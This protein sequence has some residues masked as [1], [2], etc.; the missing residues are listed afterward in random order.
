MCVAEIYL[1]VLAKSTAADPV[2]SAEFHQ[3]AGAFCYYRRVNCNRNQSVTQESE[4]LIAD[5]WE[6]YGYTSDLIV[7]GL[8]W[9]STDTEISTHSTKLSC[10]HTF[11]SCSVRSTGTSKQKL[12]LIRKR[13][14][15]PRAFPFTS[16]LRADHLRSK[17]LR[18]WTKS[19]APLLESRPLAESRGRTWSL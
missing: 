14:G 15:N 6:S 16:R 17:S 12:Q 18:V 13:P 10:Q 1:A 5:L 11:R 3:K 9:F 19:P 8:S 7:E 4:L 2:S